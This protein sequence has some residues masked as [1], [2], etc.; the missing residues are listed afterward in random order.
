MSIGINYELFWKEL[1]IIVGVGLG[2]TKKV[3]FGG[4]GCD[5]VYRMVK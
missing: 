4:N 2:M 3:I 1:H 5:R